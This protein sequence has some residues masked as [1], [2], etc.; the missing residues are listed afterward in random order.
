MTPP[1]IR[2]RPATVD[3]V[4]VLEGISDSPETGG[5]DWFGFAAPGNLR[6][7]IA[8]GRSLG[9][10]GAT[11]GI[12]VPVTVADDRI[13]GLL[14]WHPTIYG[15]NR[16]PAL[17]FGIGIVPEL[18]GQG[19]GTAAHRVLADYL[20]AHTNVN[21]LEA[22]TDIENIGEQRAAEKAGFTREGVLRGAQ[23]RSG[24]WHDM[25][26]YGMTRADHKEL[27]ASAA[28]STVRTG[29]TA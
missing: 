13:V 26:S 11:S 5:H 7:A 29:F 1:P 20:F 9:D 8:E 23:F 28:G 24:E 25:V 27:R 16:Y 22:Q 4:P 17:N 21:R 12:L 14:N 10:H 19:Y 2:L 6:K 3:D 18:R 15:P